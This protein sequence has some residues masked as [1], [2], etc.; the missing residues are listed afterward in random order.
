M[1]SSLLEQVF[2]ILDSPTRSSCMKCNSVAC[3]LK[4][5]FRTSFAVPVIPTE[6]LLQTY[7]W[8]DRIEHIMAVYMKMCVFWDITGFS[9]VEGY[10]VSEAFATSIFW[11]EKCKR[12]MSEVSSKIS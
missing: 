1:R 8:D 6:F 5:T 12:R 9:L 7:L 10:N 11:S 3:I 2:F 4:F